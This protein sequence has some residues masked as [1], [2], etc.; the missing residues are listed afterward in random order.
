MRCVVGLLAILPVTLAAQQP[1]A[2][3]AAHAP[4]NAI[5]LTYF[6]ESSD[7]FTQFSGV[8]D[9]LRVVIRDVESWHRYWTT[10]HRPFIPPPPV[11]TV[12]FER[13]MVLLASLGTRA[14]GGFAIRIEGAIAD[15]GRLVV[16]IRRSMPGTGCAL[17]AV[18]TQPVDIA[19]IPVSR[20]PIAFA[21]R[22]ERTDCSGDKAP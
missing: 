17:P 3:A 6:G 7:G 19:R 4:A 20:A 2:G 16:Q 15:S 21:E 22:V 12:D 9:S 13:E 14:S 8:S 18:V 1:R 11:P 10:I 5:S